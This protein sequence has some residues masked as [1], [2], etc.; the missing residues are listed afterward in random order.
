LSSSC[1]LPFFT[2]P[3]SHPGFF[4]WVSDVE[5]KMGRP[6]T[7]VGAGATV[8]GGGPSTPKNKKKTKGDHRLFSDSTTD[9]SEVEILG[10]SD[11]EYTP[12]AGRGKKRLPATP[13][14]D[15]SALTS[16]S[17][18]QKTPAARAHSPDWPDTEELQ[19]EL[20]R[21]TR[22]VAALKRELK[23]V[24]EREKK[25]DREMRELKEEN[26]ALM[27][28]TYPDLFRCVSFP[29]P[30]PS[31]PLPSLPPPHAVPSSLLSSFTFRFSSFLLL[32]T[33]LCSPS[34]HSSDA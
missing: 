32:L 27:R 14:S 18:K 34:P 26:D 21:K 33:D 19:Q 16:K 28:Q 3:F 8:D 5:E 13:S 4:L 22:E 9:D 25:K 1:P 31:S 24:Q 20:E 29:S 6:W 15:L 17:K 7:P 30:R 10:G 11:E 12:S 23:A 2:D